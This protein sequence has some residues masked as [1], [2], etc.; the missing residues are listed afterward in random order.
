MEF[1]GRYYFP[2]G[3]STFFVK[4]DAVKGNFYIGMEDAG[5]DRRVSIPLTYLHELQNAAY[6]I[7]GMEIEFTE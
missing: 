1:P 7:R 4:H 6:F 2:K 5:D 3:T